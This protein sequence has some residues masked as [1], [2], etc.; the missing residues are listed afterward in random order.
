MFKRLS[1][2]FSSILIHTCLGGYNAWSVYARPLNASYHISSGQAAFIFGLMIANFALGTVVVGKMQQSYSSRLIVSVGA[3]LY[4]AGYYVASQSQGS[5]LWLL[6]GI[7]IIVGW[8]LSFSY[9]NSFANALKCFPKK[10][11]VITGIIAA[12]FGFG[13]IVFSKIE[14]ALMKSGCDVLQVFQF[15]GLGSAAVIFLSALV[16]R[17]P[18]TGAANAK[19]PEPIASSVLFGDPTF[20]ALVAGMFASTFGGL[21]IVG[22]LKPMA[23]T[24]TIPED[25]ATLSVSFFA[26]GN[27]VGRVLWGIAFARFGRRTIPFALLS[28]STCLIVESQMHLPFPFLS[29]AL[30]IGLFYGSSFVLYGASVASIYGT[31]RVGSIYPQVFMFFGI[32]GLISPYFGGFCHQVTGSFVP[33]TLVAAAVVA[34]GAATALRCFQ[35][36][37]RLSQAQVES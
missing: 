2:L 19:P 20:W 15:V 14:V 27:A 33:A 31:E 16:Q 18:Q 5:Y 32:S 26:M 28:L 3:I 22:N 29:V 9:V 35:L 25:L 13:G 10:A 21:M 36:S 1:I 23:L 17:S 4:G 37:D 8:G 34:A 24:Q 30:L 11:S 7:S 6:I 12:V